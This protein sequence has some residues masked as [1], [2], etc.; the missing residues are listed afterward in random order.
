MS[1]SRLVSTMRAA[2]RIAG[3]VSLLIVYEDCLTGLLAKEMINRVADSLKPEHNIR[4]VFCR[5]DVT[6]MKKTMDRF[7]NDPKGAG[8]VVVSGYGHGKWPVAV[9][10]CLR[11]WGNDG[12]PRSGMVA[13]LVKTQAHARA[14][15]RRR[16]WLENIARTG[17]RGFMGKELDLDCLGRDL[18]YKHIFDAA[19]KTTS[20]IEV[21]LHPQAV[22]SAE[23]A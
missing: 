4:S 19:C 10:R 17:G 20:L 9:Q 15:E 11:Q 21:A 22:V 2:R 7:A 18:L 16:N 6:N 23:G 5:F 8:I 13:L 3:P 12:S 14:T 1:N